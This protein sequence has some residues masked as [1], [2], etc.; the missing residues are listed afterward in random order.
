MRAVTNIE[1]AVMPVITFPVT[2]AGIGAIVVTAVPVD[3]I[4][5]ITFLCPFNLPVSAIRWNFNLNPVF[6]RNVDDIRLDGHVFTLI[7]RNIVGNNINVRVGSKGSPEKTV[8][9]R[10]GR[11]HVARVTVTDGMARLNAANS[12][13]VAVNTVAG[14]QGIIGHAG[15]KLGVIPWIAG[16]ERHVPI[17]KTGT[18]VGTCHPLA[19]VVLRAV[20]ADLAPKKEENQTSS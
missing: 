11:V 15:K 14:I 6:I 3:I 12:V 17:H 10:I 7:E 5:V 2:V 4:F 18:L 13:P 1:R 8:K 19:K 9:I 16:T 20:D